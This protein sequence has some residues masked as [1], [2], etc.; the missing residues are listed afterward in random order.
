MPLF[1]LIL[2]LS[3]VLQF[4]L[5]WWIIAPVAFGLSL[6]KST[7]AR[8]AFLAGFSAIFFLWAAMALVIHLRNE[9]ILTAKIAALFSLPFPSLMILVTALIG[10]LVG[11]I[12]AL[13]GFYWKQFLK[14]SPAAS[15]MKANAGTP[16]TAQQ[17]FT[18]KTRHNKV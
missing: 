8:Q 15:S 13:S 18:F 11:G 7:S 9:G 16:V 6:W 5:P 3:F 2:A 17:N 14:P 1:F 12:A 4:F 10:G